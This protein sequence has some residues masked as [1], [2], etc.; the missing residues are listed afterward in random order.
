MTRSLYLLL[1]S[2]LIWCHSASWAKDGL[3]HIRYIQLEPAFVLN[4]GSTGR[5]KYLRT[6]ISLK[7]SG[8]DAAARIE[9]HEPYIRNNLVLLLSAQEPE[10]MNTPDGKE[11]VR[12]K[13]RDDIRTLM[14][15]LEGSAC[16]EELYFNSFVVQN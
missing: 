11:A 4:Y 1:L 3:D 14:E 13:A 8:H 15:K 5:M 12:L 10:A 9:L 2:L 6:D 7:A 16:V